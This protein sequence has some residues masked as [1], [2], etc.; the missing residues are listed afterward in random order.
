MKKILL[1]GD[2]VSHGKIALS[3]MLPIYSYLGFDVNT[4]ATCMVSN[5]FDYE[6][7]EIVD[8]TDY[9]E[10]TVNIWKDLGFKFDYIITGFLTNDRQIK[11]IK[12][13]ISYHEGK[14]ELF[15]DPIMGDDGSL[16]HGLST[17]LVPTMRAMVKNSSLIMPNLTEA[18]LLIG[19]S[20]DSIKTD[21]DVYDWI[22]RLKKITDAS[23]VITS[24][25]VEQKS[26]IAIYDRKDDSFRKVYYEY[27]DYKFAGTGDIFS[28][29]VTSKIMLG[30]SLYDSVKLAAE[31]ISS[32]LNREI[33]YKTGKVKEVSIEKYLNE[34]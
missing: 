31:K 28:S 26:Y 17:E 24:V 19:A 8:L 2:I 34:I 7:A 11:I 27:I 9:M 12:D 33:L 20:I 22:L 10:N 15:T 30:Y 21:E 3:C 32:F 6:K 4:L 13:L 18:G 16:Y 23:I 1:V 14:I 5:T 29:I 25:Q